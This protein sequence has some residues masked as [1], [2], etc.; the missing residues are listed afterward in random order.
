VNNL[1][2]N[3]TQARFA[4]GHVAQAKDVHEQVGNDKPS[5]QVGKEAA[6]H[7]PGHQYPVGAHT[8]RQNLCTV[9]GPQ[10][11]NRENTVPEVGLEPGSSP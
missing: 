6:G 8:T 11:L 3:E 4:S 10:A 7:I 2:R 9:R 5:T 1:R